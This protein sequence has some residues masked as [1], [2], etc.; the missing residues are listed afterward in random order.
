MFIK[1]AM[2]LTGGCCRVQNVWRFDVLIL[3]LLTFHW[4]C[5]MRICIWAQADC[6]GPNRAML[7]VLATD[8][9]TL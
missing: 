1:G 4:R 6:E 2:L 9:S 7:H 8:T 3:M 5:K